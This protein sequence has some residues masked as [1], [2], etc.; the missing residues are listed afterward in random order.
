MG[1]AFFVT[2]WVARYL[3]T[4]R[5]G[6][7]MYAVGVAE[8]CMLFWSQG[9]KEVV[10][11]QTKKHGLD[12]SFVSAS[13][14]QL[15][16]LGNTLLYG[17]LALF[18]FLF[19]D[20]EVIKIISLICGVGIWFRSFEAYE[21]WFHASLRVRLT[22]RIQFIAQ[23]LY[24]G[25]N[26]GLIL[27]KAPVIWFGVTYAV[28]L[29][30]VGIGFLA[31][32]LNQREKWSLFV[33][34]WS[35]Q[36]NLLQSAKFMM[37]ANLTLTASFIVDRLLIEYIIGL[38]AVGIYTAAMK[39][40]TTW[41][42]IASSIALS[43][44]PVITEA[45]TERDQ[46]EKLSYMFGWITSCALILIIPFYLFSDQLVY[47]LF[48]SGYQ[49]SSYVFKILVWSL[50][51]ILLNEGVKSWLVISGRT[52]YYIFAVISTVSLIVIGNL[53]VTPLYQVQGAAMVFFAAWIFGGGFVFLLFKDTREFFRYIFSSFLFPYR[54]LRKFI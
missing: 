19:I 47:L 3:G 6:T 5:F 32:Y 21:I 28:Q 17:M 31:M 8:L 26:V 36:K 13:A 15:M 4:E 49:M 37:L 30:V 23:L 27:I 46:K 50:P 7:Y 43:F 45:K 39:M 54:L 14:F 2:A 34:D 18:L 12:Q 51:F 10:I 25:A 20:N 41:T 44:I 53:I 42:F 52:R 11:H 1:L 22:V 35:H 38:E 24:M 48:G 40:T 29:I 9:L 33:K 16:A